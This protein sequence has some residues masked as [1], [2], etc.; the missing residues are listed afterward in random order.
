[1]EKLLPD[2]VKR[3]LKLWLGVLCAAIVY[4]VIH[5][6]VH[7]IQAII[8]NNFDY[9]RIVGIW[10]IEVMIK[11]VPTGIQLALF[12]GLSS[13]VTVICGY[14]LYFLM[15]KIFKMKGGLVKIIIYYCTLVLMALDPIYLSVLHFFVGGGDMNGITKGLN[16]S[17]LVVSLVYGCVAILSI[18]LI[19]KKVYPGYK[20]NFS[21]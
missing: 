3:N 11:E 19:I 17:S 1:M 20:R 14:I 10:G 2:R 9:L 16:V 21:N 18:F 7:I 4:M 13:V 5:E 6:G 15:P 8:T 12:S